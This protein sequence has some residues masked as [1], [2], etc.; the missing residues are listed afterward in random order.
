MK[1]YVLLG[2]MLTGSLGLVQA[3][4]VVE[5]VNINELPEVKVC[6]VVGSKMITGRY[7]AF[8]DYGQKVSHF[9][10]GGKIRDRKRAKPKD[11][12]SMGDIINY[13]ENNGWTYIDSDRNF[14]NGQQIHHYRFRRQGA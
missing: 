14:H 12:K 13:M 5:G 9:G 8:V 6:E 11:F 4:V 7:R 3:Q 2:L 10:K 1:K